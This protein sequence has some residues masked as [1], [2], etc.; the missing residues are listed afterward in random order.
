MKVESVVKK[1]SPVPFDGGCTVEGS[2]G[3]LDDDVPEFVRHEMDNVADKS[4]PFSRA[5]SHI[6]DESNAELEESQTKQCASD[7]VTLLRDSYDHLQSVG[8]KSNV[9]APKGRSLVLNQPSCTSTNHSA[10]SQILNI[11]KVSSGMI[12]FPASDVL[13]NES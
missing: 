6:N 8:P 13:N 3:T 11:L 9:S 5:F 1:V 10:S 2:E 12:L 4:G 7:S